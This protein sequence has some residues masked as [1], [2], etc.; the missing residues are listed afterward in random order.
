MI[1]FTNYLGFKTMWFRHYQEF[2]EKMLLLKPSSN[3]LL[4][5]GRNPTVRILL[6]YSSRLPLPSHFLLAP[7]G[8]CFNW[9]GNVIILCFL[10]IYYSTAGNLVQSFRTSGYL[11][12]PLAGKKCLMYLNACSIQVTPEFLQMTGFDP[13]LAMQTE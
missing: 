8:G 7:L 6:R 4:E 13:Q 3:V 11:K 10:A 9:E 5:T 2:A 1:Q 12:S